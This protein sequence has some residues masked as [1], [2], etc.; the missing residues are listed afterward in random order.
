MT[1]CCPTTLR[2][3]IDGTILQCNH[4]AQ[5]LEQAKGKQ[6]DTA[7]FIQRSQQLQSRLAQ[8]ICLLEETEQQTAS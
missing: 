7:K 5:E 8:L 1:I 3:S 2:M 6:L 4:L